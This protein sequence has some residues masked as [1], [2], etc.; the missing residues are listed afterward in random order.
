MRFIVGYK[1]TDT[2][3][4][5]N[6]IPEHHRYI[7]IGTAGQIAAN[8]PRS[9]VPNDYGLDV[10]PDKKLKHNVFYF[11]YTKQEVKHI[12]KENNIK[13]NEIKIFIKGC[14]SVQNLGV[15]MK[16]LATTE[17]VVRY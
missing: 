3:K 9:I 11:E 10:R 16:Q 8:L 6:I 17:I 14:L 13:P 15:T 5:Y 2:I 7:V 4:K 1:Q 12:C